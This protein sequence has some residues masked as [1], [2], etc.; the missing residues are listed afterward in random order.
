ME[1]E[2]KHVFVIGHVVGYAFSKSKF[3]KIIP[4][5]S[6]VKTKKTEKFSIVKTKKIEKFSIVKT[7]KKSKIFHRKNTKK[8]FSKKMWTKNV[9]VLFICCCNT[10]PSCC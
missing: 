4:Q 1:F 6:I 8:K 2:M 9:S 3:S 7:Q 5:F 10:H